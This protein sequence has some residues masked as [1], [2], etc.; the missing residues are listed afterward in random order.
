MSKKPRLHEVAKAIGVS[1]KVL[2][3]DLNA[4]GHDFKTHMAAVNDD[5]MAVLKK[6]YDG[7][8]E[9]LDKFRAEQQA[10]P[11]KKKRR[12]TKKSS[13]VSRRTK[14]RKA[15]ASSADAEAEDESQV[16]IVKDDSG[17]KVEQ[18]KIGGGI[19]RRRRV[20]DS[21]PVTKPAETKVEEAPKEADT[22]KV[23]K[24]PAEPQTA[25]PSTD[26]QPSV[27]RRSTAEKPQPKAE[28]KAVEAKTEE[29]PQETKPTEETKEVEAPTAREVEAP[30]QPS[31][32]GRNLSAPKRLKVVGTSTPPSET[33]PSPRRRPAADRSA[34]GTE[35]T[36]AKGLR[37]DAKAK[38][39]D[40]KAKESEAAKKK[41][42]AGLKNWTAPKVTKRDLMGMT[43]E[44]EI[45]RPTGRRQKKQSA[46][47]DKKT[48]ITTPGEQKRKIR[49]EGEIKLSDLADRMGIKAVELVRKFATQGQMVNI[50]QMLDFDT[51]TLIAS[52]YDYEVINVEQTAES[53]IES[54]AGEAQE[55]PEDLEERPAVVTI[56]GHVDHGKTSLLDYIRETKVVSREA[57]GITQHIGAYQIEHSKKRITFL[58]TPGHEAFT[59]MRA[60]GA[61]V[62]DIVVLVVAADEGVKPQTLE[63]LAHAKAAEVPMIVA[64]N[65]IDKPEANPDK[66]MQ[67]LASHEIVPEDWGGDTIFTKVSAH[68]GEGVDNM[69][70]MIL[71]TAEV[72]ELKANPNRSAGG[73]VIESQLDK[74]RGPV[75]TVIVNQG[76]LK[77]GEPIVSGS[78]FGK[79]RAM[80]DSAGQQIEEAGPSTPIEILGFGAVP[81]AGSTFSAVEEESIARKASD[82]AA[83]AKK[84]EEQRKASRVSLEEMFNRMKSGE[85]NELRVV[86]KADVQGSLE[87]IAD[88]LSKIEHKE[89]NVNVIYTAV[90]GITES[91]I[92]LAGAS[93]ALVIGFNVRPTGGAKSLAESEN[94]QIKTYS[95]IYE[96][97]DDVKSAMEGLLAPEIK[98]EQLGQAE[99][100]NVFNLTKFGTVAGCYITSGKVVRNKPARLIR[101]NVVIYEDRIGSLKRFKDDAREVAEGFECGIKLESYTDIKVGDVIECF[102]RVELSKAVS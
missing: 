44:F 14:E 102:D 32:T 35:A 40:A 52:D 8:Q 51:A 38:P 78:A 9:K 11:P 33:P 53:L 30:S 37:P 84:L 54:G 19:I 85:M 48:K 2:M 12:S 49:I 74:G 1:A 71:L 28:P 39:E 31:K 60:R 83:S 82:L 72:Q 23:E 36:K 100:R 50:H 42:A 25:Q 73:I 5:A 22:S 43:E 67:E 3:N 87:A 91:D 96:L 59:K 92:S 97:I 81:E 79:I 29:K 77:K 63:A 46:R 75:A 88:S 94:I 65:K 16:K 20:D 6:K 13:I 15:A 64:I 80:F 27:V 10:A 62:T 89:V 68:T 18:R 21:T 69:L 98:E 55:R 57:G 66:V 34:A 86:L 70:E 26:Q 58:D 56:M 61:K 45:S 41:S 24:T 7:L 99:V 95:V 76:T 17:D 47:I 4:E 101:D 93:G 90:G